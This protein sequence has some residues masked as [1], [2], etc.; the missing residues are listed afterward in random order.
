MIFDNTTINTNSGHGR[1]KEIFFWLVCFY[2]VISFM[3]SEAD[4]KH[5]Q[6]K[7]GVEGLSID[8]RPLEGNSEIES[9]I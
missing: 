3:E 9:S 2:F 1:G 4:S 5:H 7:P 6:L 8:I